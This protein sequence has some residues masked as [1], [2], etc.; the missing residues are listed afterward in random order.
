M[1][2]LLT[3]AQARMA[4]GSL[5]TTRVQNAAGEACV[6]LLLEQVAE[7]PAR[8]GYVQFAL[9]F[10]GPAATSLDQATFLLTHDTLGEMP[11]FLVPVGQRGELIEY[12]AVFSYPEPAESVAT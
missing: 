5:F 9:W 7:S 4:C 10:T 2:G 6:R 11:V 3:L 1:S 12:E 8:S